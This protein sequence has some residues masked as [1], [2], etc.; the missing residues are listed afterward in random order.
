MQ[1]KI[2]PL[3]ILALLVIASKKFDKKANSKK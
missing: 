1:E 2:F 3:I